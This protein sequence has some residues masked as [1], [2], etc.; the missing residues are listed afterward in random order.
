MNAANQ[1]RSDDWKPAWRKAMDRDIVGAAFFLSRNRFGISCAVLFA[2]AVALAIATATP[3]H[4]G[5]AFVLQKII[6]SS[7]RG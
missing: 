6:C 3:A 2:T 7:V 1:R 5:P 4:A